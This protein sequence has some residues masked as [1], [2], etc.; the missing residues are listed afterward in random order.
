MELLAELDV[1]TT[2][3]VDSRQFPVP[4]SLYSTTYDVALGTGV[5]EIVIDRSAFDATDKFVGF[6]SGVVVVD[7]G[8]V[9]V[10]SAL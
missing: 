4:V 9:A 1:A 2:D 3:D 5:H 8:V 7:E 10:A 6:A